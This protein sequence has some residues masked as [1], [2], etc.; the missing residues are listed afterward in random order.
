[1]LSHFPAAKT[2]WHYLPITNII[3]STFNI[4]LISLNYDIHF[5][6]CFKIKHTACVIV[7]LHF[8]CQYL[9][10]AFYCIEQ[11]F[12]PRK[13]SLTYREHSWFI[14]A[15]ILGTYYTNICALYHMDVKNT[16]WKNYDYVLSM[17]FDPSDYFIF[18]VH[19]SVHLFKRAV[20]FLNNK[21][22]F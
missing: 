2:I 8:F 11:C 20:T 14:H 21:N 22:I 13:L 3:F 15:F 4:K 5:A 7:I 18:L 1:M 17:R 12:T 10:S 6:I 9:T 16:F 19:R